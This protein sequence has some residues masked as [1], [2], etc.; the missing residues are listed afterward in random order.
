MS[1]GIIPIGDNFWNIRDSFKIVGTVDIGTQ[2]SLVR[3]GN[4]NFVFLDS[5]S[6]SP[7]SKAK[8][9]KLTDGGKKIE[10]IINLHPFHTLKV[11]EMHS[12]Y[13]DALLYGTSRHFKVL[14][15]LPWEE[16][17]SEDEALHALYA[18]DLLFSVPEG[19]HLY[20]D[21]EQIHFSSVLSY[22]PSS[23]TIH[24]DD[25]LMFTTYPVMLSMLG[26]RDRLSLHPTLP[27]ALEKQRNSAGQFRRWL[28][29]LVDEWG[30]ATNLCA[31]HTA[32]L[33]NEKKLGERILKALKNVEWL[34]KLHQL[35][36]GLR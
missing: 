20:T 9:D 28:L 16:L 10:A 33:L 17:C 2:A 3:L 22:H 26:L 4:G 32:P 31:A 25:T 11:A 29:T 27:L 23:K 36:Y 7:E 15:E 13:P 6:L 1:L 30:D 8:I 14:P 18:D 21:N 12:Y 5:C 19:V 35:R 34:L 24:V